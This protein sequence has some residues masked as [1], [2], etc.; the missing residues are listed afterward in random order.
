M[1]GRRQ[2]TTGYDGGIQVNA[3]SGIETPRKVE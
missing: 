3:Q 2:E 1:D